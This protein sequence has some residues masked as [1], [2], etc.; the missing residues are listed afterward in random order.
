MTVALMDSQQE[1]ARYQAMLGDVIVYIMLIIS[2]A[3]M[4]FRMHCGKPYK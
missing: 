2:S 3:T 4:R 1:G